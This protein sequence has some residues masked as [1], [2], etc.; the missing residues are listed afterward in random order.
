MSLR[1][2][3]HEILLGVTGSIAAYKA[4]EIVRLCNKAGVGVTVVMTENAVRFVAPL[5]FSALTGRAVFTSMWAEEGGRFDENHISLRDRAEML[6]IAPATA[7]IIAKIRAGIADDLLSTT[8]LSMK[9]PVLVAP[10]MN[11][12]MFENA[13]VR[14]NIA[15]LKER[16]VVFAEPGTGELAC[17][18][19]G[20]GRLAEPKEI[21]E[22]ITELLR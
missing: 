15:A 17:G 14:D 18:D 22:R 21:V 9:G 5:T 1:K 16:D 7:N 6:V 20:K 2:F 12:V 19:S 13:A 8:A 3:K 4:A 10:A 11:T